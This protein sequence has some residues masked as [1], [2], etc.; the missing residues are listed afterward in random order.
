[1]NLIFPRAVANLSVYITILS[2]KYRELIS[3]G[4]TSVPEPLLRQI[5]FL[6]LQILY[7]VAYLNMYD[8]V[9]GDLKPENVLIQPGLIEGLNRIWISDFGLA[10]TGDCQYREEALISQMHMLLQNY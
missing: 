1:M 4:Q 10:T 2:N 6:I 9:H 5:K 8:I 7:A 3:K